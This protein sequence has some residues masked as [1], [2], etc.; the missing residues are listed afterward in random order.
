M[1]LGAMIPGLTGER[2]ER[3][4]AKLAERGIDVDLGKLDPAQFDTMLRELGD[5]TIDI[6]EGH[7]QV[8]ISCE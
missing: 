4:R 8:R 5:F 3:M 1:R 6:E 7:Q 2:M